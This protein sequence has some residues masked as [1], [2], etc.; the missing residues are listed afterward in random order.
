MFRMTA[1][2]QQ[3]FVCLLARVDGNEHRRMAVLS[4]VTA[5]TALTVMNRNCLH[6]APPVPTPSGTHRITLLLPVPSILFAQ[7]PH[8]YRDIYDG[9]GR[10]Y[11]LNLSPISLSAC[12]RTLPSTHRPLSTPATPDYS[13]THAAGPQTPPAAHPRPRADT[14]DAESLSHSTTDRA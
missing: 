12:R 1:F 11:R 10:Q 14:P 4:E 3:A 8:A 6:S 7:N 9:I 2:I 5:Q 13:R